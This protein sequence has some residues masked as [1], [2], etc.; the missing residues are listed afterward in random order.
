MKITYLSTR[1]VA[2]LLTVTETTVKRWT[3]SNK[4][5]CTKTLGGHRKY[6]LQDIEYFAKENKLALA[7]VTAPLS[8]SQLERLGYAVFSRNYDKIIEIII[9]EAMEGD[10]EGMFELLMYLVKNRMK[11]AD[12]IDDLIQPALEKIGKL[13]QLNKLDVNAEHLASHTIKTAM[14]RL[15]VH[16]PQQ[17]KKN[18]KILCAC[19]EGEYHDIGL[20]A[21]GYELEL[22]GFKMLY[23]GADTPFKSLVKVIKLEKPN[24]ILISATAPSITV[25]NFMNGIKE[26]Y[27]AAKANEAKLVLGGRY[28]QKYDLK[29]LGCDAI[30]DSVRETISFIKGSSK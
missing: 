24:F 20:Q 8:K 17:R 9:E 15:I 2:D 7:G 23:L 12:L 16:L 10:R 3:D 27:K 25:T 21:L 30:V 29:K 26:V 18:I 14:S 6:T 11:F 1:E 28:V 4:L 5:N 13:W 19:S 22:K